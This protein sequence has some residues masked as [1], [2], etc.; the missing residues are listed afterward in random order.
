MTIGLSVSHL[1]LSSSFCFL[2]SARIRTQALTIE[3]A[4]GSGWVK[5]VWPVY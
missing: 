5:R 2:N 4:N 3:V 1:M